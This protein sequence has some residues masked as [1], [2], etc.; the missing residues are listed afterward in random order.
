MSTPEP[1][2]AVLAAG[3]V[4]PVGAD[5]T[6]VTRDGRAELVPILG[7]SGDADESRAWR[8]EATL[9]IPGDVPEEWLAR[10]S[11]IFVRSWMAGS[12]GRRYECPRITGPVVRRSRPVSGASWTVGVRS[13]EWHVAR[14]DFTRR[15]TVGGSAMSSL[16]RL[17][18]EALPGRLHLWVHPEIRD[19]IGVTD[20]AYEPGSG[21]RLRAVQELAAAMGGAVYAT[22]GGD[23]QLAP[24]GAPGEGEPDWVIEQGRAVVD[25]GFDDDDERF[26]NV[27]VVTNSDGG[28]D[29]EIVGVE[30]VRD[31][32]WD[33]VGDK[34]I[35]VLTGSPAH[36]GD[37]GVG[38]FVEHL[39]LPVR[40]GHDATV[41]AKAHLAG[42]PRQVRLIS[43]DALDNPWITAGSRLRF[44]GE[45]IVSDHIVTRRAWAIPSSGAMTFETRR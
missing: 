8:H 22:P 25:G 28:S 34:A 19:S 29:D 23:L 43:V 11:S 10:G 42:M 39:S 45:N 6:L 16:R 30:W 3:Q 33:Y 4:V 41:A 12:D 35:G 36:V 37:T 17:L 44:V 27:V 14:A 7:A 21:S 20:R 9:Q 2:A 18:G 1:V 38:M 26:A 24:L 40:S 15:T 13:P 32:R 5:A 31:G